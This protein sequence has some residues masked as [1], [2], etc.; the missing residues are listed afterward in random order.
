MLSTPSIAGVLLGEGFYLFP[1]G[2]WLW[3][4]ALYCLTPIADAALAWWVEARGGGLLDGGPLAAVAYA[5][6]V[7]MI[8]LTLGVAATLISA[9]GAGL[10]VLPRAVAVL[11][12]RGLGENS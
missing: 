3:G 1:R 12:G 9:L 6:T 8:A 4:V 7:I 2:F 5:L 10:R 11:R